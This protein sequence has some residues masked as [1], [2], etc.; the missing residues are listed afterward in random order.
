MPLKLLLIVA[1]AASAALLAA[2]LAGAQNVLERTQ[3]DLTSEIPSNNPDMVAAKQK[4]R[5]TLQQFL[6]LALAP[7]P[8]T[9]RF[10]VKS[11]IRDRGMVEFFWISPFLATETGFSGQIDN[12]P[13]FVQNV[14]LG[15]TVNFAE[16]D[17]VD[18]L[19]VDE[20]KL[21]GNYTLC[22]ILKHEPKKEA[23]ALLRRIRL[24]CDP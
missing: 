10:A 23:D 6:A 24:D 17:I 19:Y 4:A 2:P 1:L 15:D 8:S 3:R 5:D 11:A 20:G 13:E 12:A 22:A 18:W 9:T 16:S 14:K 21:K 7:R